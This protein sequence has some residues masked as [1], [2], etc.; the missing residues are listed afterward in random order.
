MKGD[1]ID[2]PNFKIIRSFT[3]VEKVDEALRAINSTMFFD[4]LR[5]DQSRD[6]AISACWFPWITAADHEYF[7]CLDPLR[8]KWWEVGTANIWTQILLQF[9]YPPETRE[10]SKS[11]HVDND[12]PGYKLLKV[13]GVALTECDE[14]RGG[15]EFQERGAASYIPRL[16]PGDAVIFD[17]DTWHRGAVN[18]SGS[19]RYAV[20]FRF[21]KAI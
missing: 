8:E 5:P 11:F 3:S 20:Y 18:H 21:L 2:W 12:P 10:S 14:H 9:P 7:K 6:W 13:L 1:T 4:G 16:F 15:I 17:G 19:I